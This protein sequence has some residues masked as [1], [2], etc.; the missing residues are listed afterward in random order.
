MVEE[1]E[2]SQKPVGTR[3]WYDFIGQLADALP[4]LHLGGRNATHSL[5]DMCQLDLYLP[6]ILALLGDRALDL[7]QEEDR[8]LFAR[9]LESHISG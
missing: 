9:A 3:E 7:I 4:D 5:L 2:T 8:D 1:S 6:E